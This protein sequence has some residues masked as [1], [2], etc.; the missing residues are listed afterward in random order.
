VTTSVGTKDGIEEQR[1]IVDETEE[2]RKRV[3][4]EL[5]KAES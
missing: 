4:A 5:K 3:F 1:R 2:L